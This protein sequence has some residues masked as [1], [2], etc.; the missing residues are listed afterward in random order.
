MRFR[1]RPLTRGYRGNPDCGR[2]LPTFRRFWSNLCVR[3]P[4]R[5][6]AAFACQG[7]GP[8]VPADP[9][10]A[11]CQ[12]AELVGAG[13]SRGQARGDSGSPGPKSWTGWALIDRTGWK[14]CAATA[15]SLSKRHGD[16]ARPSMRRRAARG[17]GSRTR[18]RLEPPL[19][20]P[21]ARRRAVNGHLHYA[22][23]KWRRHPARSTR[24][25]DRL[26]IDRRTVQLLTSSDYEQKPLSS[27][28]GRPQ[29]ALR[30]RD[31]LRRS[32]APTG[33]FLGVWIP[34]FL[35]IFDEGVGCVN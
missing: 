6:P 27:R 8:R 22:F 7:F 25:P 3:C 21:V 28:F 23:L 30:L 1:S 24:C 19:C 17:A 29:T 33:D 9:G 32:A 26:D 15:D 35:S 34:G 2:W 18:P 14:L 10:Q 5:G 20:R 31:W 16:R 11:L 13:T 12:A 4:S